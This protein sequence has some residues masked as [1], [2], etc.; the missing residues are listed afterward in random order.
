M[1]SISSISIAESLTGGS[2]SS[3]LVNISGISKIFKG[4]ITVY[5]LNSKIRLL[6]IQEN[7]VNES[8]GVSQFVSEEMAKNVCKLFDTN[9]GLSTTGYAEKYKENNVCAYISLYTNFSNH[10][11]NNENITTIYLEESTN[12]DDLLIIKITD[13]CDKTISYQTCE[14]DR[15]KFRELVNDIAIKMLSPYIYTFI[16][17]ISED[18]GF[19]KI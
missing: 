5:S 8:N 12:E 17:T 10:Y 18:S 4:G 14:N 3:T 15:N 13:L 11:N 9:I 19:T 16:Q 7:K 6:N 2:V 1:T